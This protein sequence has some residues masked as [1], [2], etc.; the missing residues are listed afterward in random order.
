MLYDPSRVVYNTLILEYLHDQDRSEKD[1]NQS[2]RTEEST[3]DRAATEQYAYGFKVHDH[4]LLDIQTVINSI[5]LHALVNSG[6][7]PSF[8]DE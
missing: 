4:L 5:P 3:L 1:I 8:I 6:A 7:T 2:K